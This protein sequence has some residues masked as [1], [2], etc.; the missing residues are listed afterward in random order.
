MAFA[1]I[2][3][4]LS[5][6]AAVLAQVTS[7]SLSMALF[8]DSD[9]MPHLRA[10][11]WNITYYDRDA[12]APG[13][14]FVAPYWYLFGEKHSNRWTPCQVGP[15]IYDQDGELIWAG[16]CKYE[17]RNVWNFKVV[18]IDNTPHLALRLVASPDEPGTDGSMVLLN[19]RYQEVSRT[20][21]PAADY[22]THEL[23]ITSNPRR[24]ISIVLYPKQLNLSAFGQP[25][26]TTHIDTGGFIEFDLDTGHRTFQWFADEHI[27]L[28]ESFVFDHTDETPNPDYAHLNSVQ[29]TG[30]GNYLLSARHCNTI[31]YIDGSTGHIIWR[32]GGKRSSFTANFHF[33]R[34]HD[35]R[36]LTAN[37]THMSLTFLNNAA[38]ERAV[39]EPFS[40]AMHVELDLTSMTATL[41]TLY[42]RPDGK[43]TNRRG[44]VQTIRTSGLSSSSVPGPNGT[45]TDTE[46]TN[47]LVNWSNDAYISEHTLA[48]T[49]LMEARFASHR[50][51]TYRAFKFPWVS[52]RPSQPPALVAFA[53]GMRANTSA[54]SSLST[55]VYVSWNGA[56]EVR[57]WRFYARAPRPS[58]STATY[59][60]M[61]FTNPRVE[62]GSVPKS[63]FE[64]AF[65]VPGYL[66]HIS[67]E[68][69]D[70][71]NRILGFSEEEVVTTPPYW[72][73][74][75]GAESPGPDDPEEILAALQPRPELELEPE[76]ESVL[77]GRLSVSVLLLLLA[78]VFMA[79][80]VLG[81][82]AAYL[83][84]LLARVGRV[85]VGAWRR[86]RSLGY[87]PWVLTWTWMGR[88][89]EAGY[90]KVEGGEVHIVHLAERE[91]GRDW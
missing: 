27:A 77:D 66:S 51:D 73:A 62:I 50:F 88:S 5:L 14:W 78:L 58:N 68:A 39:F 10:M 59:G 49:L 60:Y 74:G 61:N 15:Y 40:S 81:R 75:T 37:E 52:R 34:Q 54:F 72:A 71:N 17:N 64:T 9:Q 25:E 43:I 89:N 16:S 12:V 20:P 63:G 84:P 2:L 22:D 76:P 80:L 18:D 3:S 45:D 85:P 1:T 32:L 65:T 35:A 13:Y 90:S 46:T 44:N 4:L 28:D 30:N 38:D 69:L 21:I 86:V 11:K 41:L 83:P 19:D 7:T 36:F 31:Y 47:A 42:P 91:R 48:G 70:V 53:H 87:L 23:Q 24:G 26:K 8:D 82:G 79:G 6:A 55:T 56:T 29:K 57:R 67:V 33:E